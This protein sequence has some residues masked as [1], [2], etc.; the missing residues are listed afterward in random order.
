MESKINFLNTFIN[1]MNKK[2]YLKAISNAIHNKENKI[3]FYLNTHSFNLLK[4]NKEFQRNFNQADYITPD[5]FSIKWAISFLYNKRIEKVSFNHN[6]MEYIRDL[7]SENLS[8][9]FLLGSKSSTL[10]IAVNNLKCTPPTLNIVGYYNGYFDKKSESEKVIEEIN[11][12]QPDVLMVGMGMP[13]SVN[14]II[15]NKENINTKLIFTVGNLFDIIAGEKTIAPKFLY[16]TPFEWIY[17][18]AQES[19]KLFPRYFIVHPYF[20]FS[21]LKEKF[22]G[23]QFREL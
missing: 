6:F 10:K 9:I 15:K 2:D 5:G 1:I 20:I 22:F 4:T 18:L 13:D 21:V 8:R 3:F 7:F 12:A 23:Q 14:W 17:R 19:T 16:N 11:L